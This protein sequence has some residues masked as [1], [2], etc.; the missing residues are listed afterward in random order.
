MK[1]FFF[2]L[3]S[4]LSTLSIAAQAPKVVEPADIANLKVVSSPQ[5]SPDGQLVVYVVDTPVAAGKHK[6]SHLWMTSADGPGTSRPLTTGAGADSDPRWSP[7]GKSVAFL[8]DRKN[9]LEEPGSSPFHFSL[10]GVSDRADLKEPEPHPQDPGMQLWILP[11]AGG[12]ATPLTCIAGGIK[13]FR[14]SKDGKFIAFVR[15]DQETKAERDRKKDKNDEVQIDRDYKYDRLWIYD[16]QAHQ[17]RLMTRNNINIDAFDWSPNG[18]SIVARVS[19]TPRIDDYWRVSKIVILEAA[20]GEIRRTLEEHAGYTEPRWSPDGHRI[21][22]SRMRNL[23]ITDEHLIID[24]DTART[25]L[26]EKEFAG[27]VAQMEWLPDGSGLLAHGYENAHMV[28]LKVNAKSGESTVLPGLIAPAGD[29]S[30]GGGGERFAYIG[31]TPTEPG[32]VWSYL[33]GK[34]IA[35]TDTNPQV[36][37]WKLGTER[38]ISWKNPHDGHI[39]YGVVDLPPGYTAG[40]RY[41]TIVHVHGGP[42]EA[43]ALGWHGNWYNY[44]AMLASNGYVVLLPDPRG[45]DGQGPAFTEANYRDWGGGDFQDVMAGVDY[46]VGQGIADPDRLAIGGWSFGGFM[47]SWAVTHTDRF[48]AGMVGAAVTDLFSMATTTDISPSFEQSYFGEL[49]SSRQFYDDHSPVRFISQCHTPVLILHG[50]ADPRVPISQGEEFYNALRFLGRDAHM[51]TYPR[52]PHI[53][54]EREHQID[55]LSRILGWYNSHL[56]K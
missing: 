16:V 35:L 52:E 14:W 44:A 33:D 30:I 15:T 53:F 1:T 2:L 42:E 50:Q 43:W 40:T 12:E 38:E 11:L 19:P 21:A 18:E 47:T 45:S 34:T 48:K 10:L 13:S 28:I 17:A 54:K 41:K 36:K 24:L 31:E 6:D 56:D 25:I 5:I 37:N 27:T 39:I 49:Q 22:Y 8:S 3:G 26:V 7:D 51:V 46:L 23:R 9:P 29:I 32:E 55:S 4:L 20:N